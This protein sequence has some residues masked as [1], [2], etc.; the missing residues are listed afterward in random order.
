MR[1]S[2]GVSNVTCVA[3]SAQGVE[4]EI[5]LTPVT[6]LD[7]ILVTASSVIPSFEEHRAIGLGEL[8]NSR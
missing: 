6:T 1:L 5:L 7:S 3:G 8:H 2:L 4:H